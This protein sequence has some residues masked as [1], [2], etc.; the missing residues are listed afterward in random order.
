MPSP[1]SLAQSRL[2]GSATHLPI[3][4]AAVNHTPGAVLEL[5]CGAY[6]TPV[7][8]ALC[9]GRELLS[10]E[11]DPE[12]FELFKRFARGTHRV[13]RVEDWNKAAIERPW[14]VAFVDHA[15]G[16]Q[17][18]IDIVRLKPHAKIIVAHDTE[19]RTYGYEP[20]FATFKYRVEWRT[21][22]PWA[23][24]VSDTDDLEWLKDVARD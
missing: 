19:H 13:E 15:P 11:Q 2:N 18:A 7:L 3:L 12:W 22:S 1:A 23:V 16:A 9:Q 17:R 24:A 20:I 5:G 14:G 4:I 8:H 6:S 10:L 21:Y